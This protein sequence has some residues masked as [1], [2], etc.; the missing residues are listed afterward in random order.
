[1]NL[2][3]K[4]QLGKGQDF[5]G[6]VEGVGV[7]NLPS[8]SSAVPG[9]ESSISWEL[10]TE[11]CVSQGLRNSPQILSQG[12]C[13]PLIFSLCFILANECEE[14]TAAIV[15][16]GWE[17]AFQ[18]L[19]GYLLFFILYY[20]WISF[21]VVFTWCDLWENPWSQGLGKQ[22]IAGY[23]STHPIPS[24]QTQLFSCAGSLR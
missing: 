5:L 4:E 22:S 23:L 15:V 19:L 8:C 18:L 14:R 13:R 12:C 2:S 20:L 11:N 24:T 21:E 9:V 7:P 17:K 3:Q 16:A 10:S 1:M 6:G